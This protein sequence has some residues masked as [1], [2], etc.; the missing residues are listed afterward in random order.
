[1]N[2][3]WVPVIWYIV[4]EISTMIMQRFVRV[5]EPLSI[6]F[7]GFIDNFAFLHSPYR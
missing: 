7:Q 2:V 3:E 6:P 4:Y 1:M 5:G